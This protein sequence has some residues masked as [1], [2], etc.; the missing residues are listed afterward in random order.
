MSESEFSMSSTNLMLGQPTIPHSA[1]VIVQNEQGKTVGYFY[2]RENRLLKKVA[3]NKREINYNYEKQLNN[4]LDSD[5]RGQV[6]IDS[7]YI[8]EGE[9]RGRTLNFVDQD[10]NKVLTISYDGHGDKQSIIK[11]LENTSNKNLIDFEY[12]KR[13]NIKIVDDTNEHHSVLDFLKKILH[14]S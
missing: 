4:M 6:L 14:V 8:W 12:I 1:Y 11:E 10:G 13:H 3:C 7:I 5:C 9:K 2:T